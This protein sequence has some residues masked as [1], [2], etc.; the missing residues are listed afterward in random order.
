MM[1]STADLRDFKELHEILYQAI[2]AMSDM[3]AGSVS[4]R[5]LLNGQ[6]PKSYRDFSIFLKVLEVYGVGYL[7]D[8]DR[9]KYNNR[10]NITHEQQ[11]IEEIQGLIEYFTIL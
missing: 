11:A 1:Q 4:L 8:I 9:V 10:Q 3:Q 2:L 7:D 6:K 5:E